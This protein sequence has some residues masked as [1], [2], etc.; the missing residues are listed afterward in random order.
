MRR[1]SLLVAIYLSA[2][3]L[4][5]AQ[6]AVVLRRV[7][8]IDGTGAA[9]IPN[10][11]VVIQGGRILAVGRRGTVSLPA[12]ATEQ[13]LSGK[14]LVPGFID[15]HAHVAFGPVKVGQKPG[16][17]R[18]S[19]VYDHEASLMMLRRLLE[20]GVTTVRNPAGPTLEAVALRDQVARG[21]VPGPRVFTAGAVIDF[22]TSPGLAVGASTDS[23]VRAEVRAQAR[24]G[25]DYIKLYAG[26]APPLIAAGVDEAHRQGRKAIAHT[27]LTS[28]TEAAQSGIDG[29]VHIVPGSPRLLPPDRRPAYLKSMTGTQFMYRWFEYLDPAAAEI[30]TMIR[31]LT[32]HQVV[33]DPTLVTFEA[34]FRGNDPLITRSPDLVSA[35]P[36]LLRNWRE[37]FTLSTGW[38]P[39]EFAAAQSVWPRVLAFTRLLYDRGVPL[40]VGTDTPN[41]WTAPGTS[42]HRELELL[43]GTGIPPLEVLRLATGSGARALG[44]LD[45]IGTIAP[46]KQADLVLLDADPVTDI[47]NS[48]RIVWVMQGGELKHCR[49]QMAE[50]RL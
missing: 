28:W 43:A 25:V 30:D 39:E 6:P 31:A 49:V 26:L 27:L 37:D 36:T 1:I 13:N 34:M 5:T 45:Q 19:M 50:C 15:M 24:A 41:P 3:E 48:R 42:F 22:M 40:V 9:P 46:G 18:L 47:R 8:V 10:A 16:E 7:T 21:E 12:D 35:P 20:Y 2:V 44:I 32:A 4:L 17:P 23:A 33:L 29:I 14:Y 38:K 11:D